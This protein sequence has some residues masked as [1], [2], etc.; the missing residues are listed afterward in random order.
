MAPDRPVD[1][2]EALTAV[3]IPVDKQGSGRD[4]GPMQLAALLA[5]GGLFA[6]FI[7]GGA[8]LMIV[9]TVVAIMK[10][11]KDEFWDEPPG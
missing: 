6:L 11:R 8:I 7:V 3:P 10:M 9:L 1:S 2:Y 5:L 4:A